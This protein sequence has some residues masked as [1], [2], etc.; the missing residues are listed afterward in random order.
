MPKMRRACPYRL[1]SSGS[2]C[3][4]MEEDC[5]AYTYGD[6]TLI[7]SGCQPVKE[8]CPDFE[9]PDVYDGKDGRV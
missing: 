7:M 3:W 6:C 5:M 2:W 4:C 1:N 8:T 9:Y